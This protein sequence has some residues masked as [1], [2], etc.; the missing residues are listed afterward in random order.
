[1]IIP[2]ADKAAILVNLFRDRSY[3]RV[4]FIS[5]RFNVSRKYVYTI[6]NKVK[7]VLS[8]PRKDPKTCEIKLLTSENEL[9]KER[10]AN[11][12]R[13]INE[14]EKE[15][16]EQSRTLR[17]RINDF[18]ILAS[19][20]VNSLRQI[21]KLVRQAFGVKISKSTIQRRIDAVSSKAKN[22]MEKYFANAS[23]EA[24][25]DEIFI[26][27]QPLLTSVCPKSLAFLWGLL[28]KDR[29]A[30][31]W[32]K[33]LKKSPDLKL[34]A[35]DMGSGLVKGIEQASL[36]HQAD[37]FHLKRLCNKV[38]ASFEDYCYRLIKEE[39]KT[40][41]KLEKKKSMGKYAHKEGHAYLKAKARAIKEIE[42][43]DLAESTI[44]KDLYPAFEVL[45]TDGSIKTYH[46]AKACI[47]KYADILKG[48]KFKKVKSIISYLKNDSLLTFL[49]ILETR[50]E[51]IEINNGLVT[52]EEV[53]NHITRSWYQEKTKN[54]RKGA[55]PEVR[56]RR[57]LILS[58]KDFL[59]E[60]VLQKS[61]EGYDKIKTEVVN[62]LNAILRSSSAV[63]CVNSIIRP[64]QQIKK[65]FSES[66]IYLVAL[67]HNLH[68]FVKG[69][70]RAGKSPAEILGVK[71]PTSDFFELLKTV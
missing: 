39:Y 57:R 66:F 34:A 15:Q 40:Q 47:D 55:N 16:Q 17:E 44:K 12:E 68:T 61:L 41:E 50:L 70:K 14:K 31:T 62:I 6:V 46:K 20:F 27:G 58:A 2:P 45:G 56:S 30:S 32:E 51:K 10:V 38:L 21:K 25:L 43:F 29:K 4:S 24:A 3:G 48:L 11:L 54:T 5:D 23:K 65:R 28:A 36:V 71:L 64:Y 69:S 63:E 13:I 9:L 37:L 49:R 60:K 53:I 8:D 35:S 1:M 52:K 67:Y 7:F 19:V 22:L 33:F 42:K 59:K 18:I 26:G